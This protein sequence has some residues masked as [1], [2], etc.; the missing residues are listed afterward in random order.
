[1]VYNNFNHS[2]RKEILMNNIVICTNNLVPQALFRKVLMNAFIQADMVGDTHVSVV[3]HYPVFENYIYLYREFVK[4]EHKSFSDVILKEPFFDP[5]IF[6]STYDNMVVGEC[7]YSHLTIYR[8]LREGAFRRL[9]ANVVIMEHDVLYPLNYLKTVS[10][11]LNAGMD[12]CYW[13]KGKFFS[14]SGFFEVPN[15]MTLSRFSMKWDQFIKV[16]ENKLEKK[17]T[18]VE[19]LLDGIPVSGDLSEEVVT[20]KFAMVHGIDT[21]D[22]RH[23]LNVSGNYI[24]E[25]YSDCHE[26]WGSASEIFPLIDGPCKTFVEKHP[27]CNYGIW[28]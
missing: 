26:Y 25:E 7:E 15:V 1:M 19:P 8:Q 10:G 24:V 2:N 6:E 11:I 16:F 14:N 12:A 23:G 13:A 3:S 21:L 27:S 5:D 4:E 20:R 18:F 28:S 17:L 22:I 9:E